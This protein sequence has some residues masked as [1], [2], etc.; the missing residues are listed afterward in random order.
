MILACLLTCGRPELTAETARSFA[1]HNPKRPDIERV[2][3][4]G[5]EL[6]TQGENCKTAA[7]SGFETISASPKRIGQMETL[8]IF[9]AEAERRGAHWV[10]WLENDWSTS[11][12]LPRPAFFRKALRADVEAIRLFG[13]RKMAHEGPRSMAGRH[14]MGTK[15]VVVW[16]SSKDFPGWETGRTHWGCGGCLI[17]SDILARHMRAA[18]LKDVMLADNNLYSLRP[19]QNLVWHLGQTRTEGFIP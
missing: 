18:T 8:R 12:P 19:L 15:D 5:G 11:E 10:L 4:D 9:Q 16:E 3:V 1:L 6:T 2:H 14:R 7:A 17:R 13:D